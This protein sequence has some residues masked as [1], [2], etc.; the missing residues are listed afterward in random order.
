MLRYRSRH[1][2]ARQIS[3]SQLLSGQYDPTW[4]EDRVVLMGTTAAS[5]KDRFYTPFSFNQDEDLTMPG[6]IIH[7][8][9]VSQ[10]LDLLEG[11]PTLYRYLPPGLRGCG[12][13]AGVWR[14][15]VWCGC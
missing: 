4:L 9:M 10:L 14:R 2:P 12:C 11:K 6:V 1:R 7:A 15:A 5:L 8:Q 13:G 3:I